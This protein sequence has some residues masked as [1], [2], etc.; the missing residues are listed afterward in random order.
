MK[1]SLLALLLVAAPLAASA[2]GTPVTP[3]ATL[4]TTASDDPSYATVVAV[5][6][7]ARQTRYAKPE[8]ADSLR[9]DRPECVIL[10]WNFYSQDPA[11]SD[12]EDEL[13][14]INAAIASATRA[15]D[16]SALVLS[17]LTEARGLW[18]L[19]TA[20]GKALAASLEKQLKEKT[21]VPV[22]IRVVSDPQW[23]RF[24]TFV[25]RLTQAE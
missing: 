10:N 23:S 13:E 1:I 5:Y 22:V 4:T 2:S 16:K 20:A 3:G 6:G 18:V 12:R 21:K 9:P 8:F 14:R 17:T 15:D 11:T 24:H 7:G 25:T 19:Y